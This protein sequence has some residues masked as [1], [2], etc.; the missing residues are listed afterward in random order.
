[1]VFNRNLKTSFKKSGN[2][3]Q[4]ARREYPHKLIKYIKDKVKI[5]KE[6][7]VLDIGCGTGKSTIPFA[8]SGCSILGIDI[9]RDMVKEAKKNSRKYENLYYRFGSFESLKL[10]KNSFD[11]VLAGASFHWLNPK[12]CY[13]KTHIIL[14][15]KGYLA[16]FWNSPVFRKSKVVREL[17]K[18]FEKEVKDFPADYE[19]IEKEF[20]KNI[21]GSKLFEKVEFNKFSVN[22]R[23]SK[24]QFIELVNTYAWVISLNKNKRKILLEQIKDMLKKYKEPIVFPKEYKVI[25]AKKSNPLQKEQI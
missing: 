15:D 22:E 19:K 4:K 20:L 17:K 10:P 2:L 16:I 13:K 1:M 18:I 25:I 11:V 9:S 7:K 5:E 23:F 3:Y 14:K 6:S 12:T 8:K 21:K 24:K